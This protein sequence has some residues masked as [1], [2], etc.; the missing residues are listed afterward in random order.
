VSDRD[1]SI[2]LDTYFNV[3]WKDQ[4]LL[5]NM[6]YSLVDQVSSSCSEHSSIM[7]KIKPVLVQAVFGMY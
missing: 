4:R 2:T 6:D 3:M 1:F 7:E 5:T